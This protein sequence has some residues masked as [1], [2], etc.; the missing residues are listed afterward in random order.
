MI[1]K[2]QIWKVDC[3]GVGGNQ[4]VR[5]QAKREKQG[6][7]EAW[8][9]VVTEDEERTAM[10]RDSRTWR[11]MI[12]GHRDGEEISVDYPSFPSDLTNLM[13]DDFINRN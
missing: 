9:K 4:M 13:N 7:V 12:M 1:W 2:D 6:L 3:E 8:A 10:N 5:L 11:L